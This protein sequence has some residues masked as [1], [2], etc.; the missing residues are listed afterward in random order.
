MRLVV[1]SSMRRRLQHPRVVSGELLHFHGPASVNDRRGLDSAIKA[2]EH[3][4]LES[5]SSLNYGNDS[6]TIIVLDSISN[7]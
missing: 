5:P 1:D 6:V 3:G 4:G 7:M 2:T